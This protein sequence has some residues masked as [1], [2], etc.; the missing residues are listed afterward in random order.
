M[1]KGLQNL[2]VSD[3]SAARTAFDQNSQKAGE[4]GRAVS[5]LKKVLSA[6]RQPDARACRESHLK[7][8]LAR[9][10]IAVK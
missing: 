9:V 7:S 4:S 3:A 2:D 5:A 10:T 1:R 8:Q 6:Q